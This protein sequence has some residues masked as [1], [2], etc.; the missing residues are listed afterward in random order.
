MWFYILCLCT[1]NAET[2][3]NNEYEIVLGGWN[4]T[5]SVIR[6]NNIDIISL[7]KNNIANG[8]NYNTIKISIVNDILNIYKNN[9]FLSR[10]FI[11]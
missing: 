9:I 7:V 6:K 2:K 3:N 10:V 8:N 11:P 5:C 4:N 1:E